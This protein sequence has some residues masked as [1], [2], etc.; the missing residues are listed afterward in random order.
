MGNKEAA[1]NEIRKEL[2]PIPYT[3]VVAYATEINIP[4]EAVFRGHIAAKNIVNIFSEGEGKLTSSSVELG[5][6]VRK[7]QVI[8]QMRQKHFR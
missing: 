4:G 7:G 1:D 3:A 5:R 2:S 6:T 8:G